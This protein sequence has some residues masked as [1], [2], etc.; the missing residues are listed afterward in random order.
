MNDI[1]FQVKGDIA[2]LYSHFNRFGHEN[3]IGMAY[4][5]SPVYRHLLSLYRRKHPE[6]H[7]G[8]PPGEGGFPGYNSGVVLIDIQ[9]LSLSSI[10]SK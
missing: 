2:E 7:L 6:T 10:I 3:V 1:Y 8:N 4:E 9:K 5:Q